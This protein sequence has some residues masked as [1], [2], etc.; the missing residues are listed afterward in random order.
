MKAL[1]H[2]FFK[3]FKPAIKLAWVVLALGAQTAWSALPIEHEKLPGGVDVYWV[4]VQSLPMV[5]IQIDFDAGSRKDPVHQAGLASIVSMMLNKGVLAQGQ[6][7]ALDENALGQAWADL[8]AV[9]V[10]SA[11]DDRMSIY[12]RSLSQASVL[13]PAMALAYRQIASPAFSA[14]IWSREKTRLLSDLKESLTQPGPVA[15]RAFKKAVMQEH[16][17]G[18]SM[19]QVSIQGINVRDL[20][21]F[22]GN[23][24]N[25]CG[26]KISMVGALSREEVLK[27]ANGLSQHLKSSSSCADASTQAQSAS[28]PIHLARVNAFAPVKPLERAQR[29]NIPFNSAQSHVLMGQPG[30]ER[31]DPRYFPLTVGNYILG[32]GGFVSRLTEQVREKRGLSYSVYSYFAP[33]LQAG[34][35]TMGL[36]TR[37]DQTEQALKVVQDVLEEFVSEGPTQEELQAAKDNL[38]GGFALRIDSNKKLLDNVANVAWYHLPL[39]YLQTWSDEVQKVSVKDVHQAFKGLIDPKKMVSVV[40]GAQP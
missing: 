37:K 36:Q 8:G 22:H 2:F 26:A 9:F 35:F 31:A 16:P 40:V 27:I 5:D 34:P 29:I 11:G 19:T 21:T 15:A 30:I 33:A 14:A 13:N 10:A 7:P 18:R 6:N 25:A 24:L 38:I 20:K 1:Q 17:Y 28:A 3:S 23:H 39:D 32:G 12:I 4:Q